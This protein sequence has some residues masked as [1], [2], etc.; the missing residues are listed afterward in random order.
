MR[1]ALKS[2]DAEVVARSRDLLDKIPYGITPDSPR[3]FVELIATARAGGME[4][5]K[6][7]VQ[8]LLDLGPPGLELAEKLA[9]RLGADERERRD[10]RQLLDSEV[11]RITPNLIARG[12]E[13]RIE[14]LLERGA[15]AAAADTD[16]KPRMP[17]GRWGEPDDAARLVAWLCSDD[18]R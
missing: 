4:E 11:W 8:D 5:W 13:A 10:R 9:Q 12:D 14:E 3:R 15:L 6:K 2:G 18:G 16:P 17:F 1:A 7:V